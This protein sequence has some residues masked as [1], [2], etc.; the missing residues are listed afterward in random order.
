MPTEGQSN[1]LNSWP[2]CFV[3]RSVLFDGVLLGGGSFED[4]PDVATVDVG[5]VVGCELF[6]L[7]PNGLN[8]SSMRC[9]GEEDAA[10][11]LV[12][13]LLLESPDLAA[14][15]PE[16]DDA[17]A[18]KDSVRTDEAGSVAGPRM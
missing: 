13:A 12:G 2:V 4:L 18:V 1:G 15:V 11:S 5:D 7:L 17:G 10:L 8:S 9:E 16:E 3:A 14:N 6:S